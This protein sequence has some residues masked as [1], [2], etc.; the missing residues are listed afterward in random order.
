MTELICHVCGRKYT[1]EHLDPNSPAAYECID[2]YQAELEPTEIVNTT[3]PV[4][5]MMEKKE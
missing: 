1:V 2:C 3:E 4:G 5:P